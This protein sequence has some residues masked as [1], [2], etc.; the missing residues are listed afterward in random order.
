MGQM[1][2]YE[3]DFEIFMLEDTKSY[4]SRKGSTWIQEDSCP[5]YMLKAEECLRKEKE[6]VT[7]YLHSTTEPKLVEVG[8][9]IFCTLLAES[10]NY[11]SLSWLQAFVNID[12]YWSDCLFLCECR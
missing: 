9:D 3:E 8:Y 5:D 4:Y 7:H 1:E 11:H 12:S 10:C 6:R 2:K